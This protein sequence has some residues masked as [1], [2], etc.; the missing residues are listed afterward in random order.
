MTS[1]KP[2][3]KHLQQD[4][5]VDGTSHRLHQTINEYTLLDRPSDVNPSTT[6]T[7]SSSQLLANFKS[8]FKHSNIQALILNTSRET[9]YYLINSIIANHILLALRLGC[10]CPIPNCPKAYLPAGER[11]HFHFSDSTPPTSSFL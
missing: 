6:F 4:D 8:V 11:Q 5:N 1:H 9:H 2:P 10:S 7:S 3:N